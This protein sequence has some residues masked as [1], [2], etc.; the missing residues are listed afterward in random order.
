MPKQFL[1]A[2]EHI[3]ILPNYIKTIFGDVVKIVHHYG[4]EPLGVIKVRLLGIEASTAP[5]VIVTDAHMEAQE[6]WL[7]PLLYEIH[8]DKRIMVNFYLDAIKFKEGI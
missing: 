1:I 6:K 2:D 4:P 5:V 3:Y 8:K 7:E